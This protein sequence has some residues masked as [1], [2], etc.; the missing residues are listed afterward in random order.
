MCGDRGAGPSGLGGAGANA[1]RLERV[2]RVGQRCGLSGGSGGD[3]VRRARL[4][5]AWLAQPRTRRIVD[6]RLDARLVPPIE[7]ACRSEE[8]TSELQSL[9]RISDAV[10]CLKKNK[11]D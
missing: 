6:Q 9:M 1:P 4:R 7:R 2:D 3:L 5:R 8:H 11:T 10:F